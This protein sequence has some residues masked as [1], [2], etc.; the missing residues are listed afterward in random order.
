VALAAVVAV[1][2]PLFGGAWFTWTYR[3]LVLLVVACP[4]ALVIST[5]VSIVA[6]L[7]AAARRG[8]LIKGGVHLETIARIRCVAFDK[9]GTLTRGQPEVV[10]V[11]P[12]AGTTSDELLALAASIERRSEH[13]IAVAITAYADTHSAVPARRR[14]RGASPVGGG[15]EGSES[16]PAG[17]RHRRV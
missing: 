17:A 12:L 9:T 11:L 5:P 7:S 3:A 14:G 13:P 6:M 8:V 1:V 15:A 2:P 10:D 4:C 16:R